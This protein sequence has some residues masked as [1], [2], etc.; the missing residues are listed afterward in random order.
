MGGEVVMGE[1]ARIQH[2]RQSEHEMRRHSSVMAVGI[3]DNKDLHN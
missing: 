1:Q 3:G 2:A